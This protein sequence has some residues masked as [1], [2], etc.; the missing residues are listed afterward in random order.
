[1]KSATFRRFLWA[2]VATLVVAGALW[3]APIQVYVH[4]KPIKTD[5]PPVQINGVTYLP[6]R[7]TADALGAKLEWQE[8]TKTATLCGKT[9]CFPIRTTD[10]ASGA[11]MINGRVFLALR[12]AAE[13]L[14]AK[15]S[16]DQKNNR[17]EITPQ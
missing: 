3:A 13:A 11:K 1:M 17:V 14:G 15:V 10:P 2:L 8:S 6:L 9:T 7:A 5:T 4:G 16:Y 12:K